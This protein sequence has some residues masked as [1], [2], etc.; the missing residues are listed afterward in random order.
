M[1]ETVSGSKEDRSTVKIVAGKTPLTTYQR[2]LFSLLLWHALTNDMTDDQ[3]TISLSTLHE[4]L[5]T[6]DRTSEWILFNLEKIAATRIRW[7]LYGAADALESGFSPLLAAGWVTGDT[8][9]FCLPQRLKQFV[10]ER[11]LRRL[12]DLRVEDLFRHPFSSGIYRMLLNYAEAGSTGWLPLERFIAAASL[13]AST[14]TSGESSLRDK[15]LVP[16]VEEISLFSE[17]AASAVLRRQPDTGF[18]EVKFHVR[19]KDDDRPDACLLLPGSGEGPLTTELAREQ[20]FEAY[21]AGLVCDAATAM[22]NGEMAELQKGF[23]ESIRGNAVMMKK[24]EK[25]GFDSLA[26]KLA[27]EVYLEKLLLSEEQRDLGKFKETLG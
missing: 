16:A 25:D 24:Y 17:L 18:L 27:F 9:T 22:N 4:R 3:H 8:L 6:G 26:V 5:G 12:L 1:V 19:R 10:G 7:H 21:K 13:D 15:I 11:R 20:R 23:V 2:R 14:V